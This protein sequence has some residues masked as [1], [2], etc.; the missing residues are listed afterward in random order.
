VTGPWQVAEDT[1]ERVQRGAES[2]MNDFRKQNATLQVPGR[3]ARARHRRALVRRLR[4]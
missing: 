3:R 1:L 2:A 4:A